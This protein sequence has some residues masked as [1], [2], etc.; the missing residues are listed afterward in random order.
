ML[1]ECE[2]QIPTALWQPTKQALPLIVILNVFMHQSRIPKTH[3]GVLEQI[4]ITSSDV[5][6]HTALNQS[7]VLPAS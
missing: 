3:Q 7:L 2:Y 1:P 6:V 4:T 5:E